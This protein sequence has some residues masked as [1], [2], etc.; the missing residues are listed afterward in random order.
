MVDEL[1]HWFIYGYFNM[2]ETQDDKEG[3]LYV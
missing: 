2:V 3:L 1:A